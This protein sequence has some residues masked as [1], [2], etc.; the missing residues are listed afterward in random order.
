MKETKGIVIRVDRELYDKIESHTLPQNELVQQ[1]LKQFFSEHA[2]NEQN[3]GKIIPDE[4]YDEVYTTL[5]HT[6]MIPLKQQ[7]QHQQ[8]LIEVL[9]KQ[10]ND[11]RE[12]KKFLKDLLM[13]LQNDLKQRKKSFFSRLKKKK[14]E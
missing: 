12:D 4:V 3:D 9:Q 14:Q 8:D 13:Q 5:Y 2:N 10:V 1:A 11:Y 6:E 7:L